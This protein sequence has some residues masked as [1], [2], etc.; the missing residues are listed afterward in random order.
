[1]S[2]KVYRIVSR[3]SPS[4]PDKGIWQVQNR[5]TQDPNCWKGAEEKIFTYLLTER[6]SNL[7]NA[8]QT[9]PWT[10]VGALR[11]IGAGGTGRGAPAQP[12]WQR[13]SNTAS[14][15]GTPWEELLP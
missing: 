13:A 14:E 10:P 3:S 15:R 2:P 5:R 7:H 12:E 11:S 4:H 1:M 9:R 8:E 6:G